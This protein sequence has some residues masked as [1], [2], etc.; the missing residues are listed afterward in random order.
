MFDCHRAILAARSPVFWAMLTTDMVEART[1][2]VEIKDRKPEVVYAMLEYIYC[3]QTKD[4]KSL[5]EE[6]LQTA[7]Y[8]QISSLKNSSE[9]ELIRTISVDNCVGRLILGEDCQAAK[10]KQTALQFLVHNMKRVVSS[11]PDWNRHM[12]HTLQAQVFEYIADL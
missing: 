1:N 2:K 6:L 7:N 10:L 8:Y 4:L 5:A 3:G 9:L 11:N 12:S